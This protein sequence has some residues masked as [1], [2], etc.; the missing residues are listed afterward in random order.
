MHEQEIVQTLYRRLLTLY[1]RTFKE[2]LGESMEQTFL[3]L[4]REKRQTKKE[5]FGFVLWTFIAAGD[6]MQ[7]VRI[8]LGSSTAMSFLLVLPLLILELAT[9]SNL[10][11]SNAGMGLF[12]YLWLLAT[13]S[14][15]ILT[16]LVRKVRE[17]TAHHSEF[18]S[19]FAECRCPGCPWRGV[20][21]MGYRSNAVFSRRHWL[22]DK[23]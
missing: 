21:K 20:A 19:S 6:I 11:R 4:W 7:T 22:L 16:T 3:D 23:G 2:R 12:V 13:I 8:T 10:P 5:L 17:G 14:F 1:P 15:S 18:C 9:R